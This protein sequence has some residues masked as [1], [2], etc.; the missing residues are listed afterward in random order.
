MCKEKGKAGKESSEDQGWQVCP[1]R[2][3]VGCVEV[4]EVQEGQPVGQADTFL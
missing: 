2:S 3:R 4:E 1:V